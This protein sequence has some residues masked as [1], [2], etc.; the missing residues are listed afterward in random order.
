MISLQGIWVI[1]TFFL[2]AAIL[3][4]T[5]PILGGIN[6]KY[7]HSLKQSLKLLFF[8]K[9]LSLPIPD[10][11]YLTLYT[12]PFLLNNIIGN[13]YPGIVK[14][15]HNYNKRYDQ[16]SIWI[17]EAP[18]RKPDDPIIIYLH[19][20]GY[21][22]Q[23]L[24]AQ[25]E[26]LL[27]IYQLVDPAKRARL[28]V[29]LL[30]YSLASN[31]YK[32][33]TQLYELAATYKRLTEQEGNTNIILA[34][35]SAGG[36]LAVTFTQWIHSEQGGSWTYP[37]SLVLLSPWVK[38]AADKVQHTP[39][40]SYHDNEK[41]DLI[42][43]SW[44]S[45]ASRAQALKGELNHKTL[46]VSPG[47]CPY[48][49]SDWDQIPT[50]SK[51]GYSVFVIAGEHE[52]FLDDIIEFAKY[53]V[54]SRLPKP[55]QD[56][57]GIFDPHVHEYKREEPNGPYVDVIIEPWGVHVGSLNFENEIVNKVNDDP[58]LKLSDL[59]EVKYFGI[60]K[61]VKFLNKVLE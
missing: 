10:A 41:K 58:N 9:Q 31:G 21:Y 24:I 30:D 45:Q 14:N 33:T 39:G 12:N 27:S 25:I 47:N 8:R 51:P 5:Y 57:R 18:N 28:S 49:Q 29:L 48:K 15:L 61:I 1:I 16:Q 42:Q 7:K 50:F 44:F 54:D 6:P 38:L 22:G 59:D 35:D 56:S 13:L 40:H 2:E 37:R 52:S 46:T 17:N 60:V 53:A 19:G 26:G 32:L 36:H 55:K 3:I 20:G 23:T 4:L 11:K 43:Y 34:G